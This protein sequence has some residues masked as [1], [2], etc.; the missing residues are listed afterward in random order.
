MRKLSEAEA[1]A[2]LRRGKALFQTRVGNKGARLT[3]RAPRKTGSYRYFCAVH[4]QMR[5]VLVVRR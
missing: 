5:G 2:R 3:A 4:P 1:L